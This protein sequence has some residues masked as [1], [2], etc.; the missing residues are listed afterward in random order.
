MRMKVT[1][2][3]NVCTE[4]ENTRTVKYENP[5]FT[6]WKTCKPKN[7]DHDLI[8]CFFLHTRKIVRTLLNSSLPHDVEPKTRRQI[9]SWPTSTINGSIL[10]IFK[11]KLYQSVWAIAWSISSKALLNLWPNSHDTKTSV[12]DQVNEL[13]LWK[14]TEPDAFWRWKTENSVFHMQ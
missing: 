11:G 12:N 14:T 4:I 13:R 1:Q 2:T 6:T 9:G 5:L 7:Y 3:W 8:Q 10:F